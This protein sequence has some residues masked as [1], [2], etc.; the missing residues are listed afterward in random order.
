[1]ARGSNS[2]RIHADGEGKL[3]ATVSAGL[4]RGLEAVDRR[5]GQGSAQALLAHQAAQGPTRQGGR[6]RGL[7]RRLEAIGILQAH[8]DGRPVHPRRLEGELPGRFESSLLEERLAAALDRHLGDLSRFV[9]QE[10]KDDLGGGALFAQ[11]FGGSPGSPRGAAEVRSRARQ[12]SRP[13]P[14]RSRH[15]LGRRRHPRARAPANR[16]RRPLAKALRRPLR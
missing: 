4:R 12:P 14:L 6:R 7:G 9:D 15:R 11:R 10:P 13:A 1:M 8:G 2:A 3:E 5:P 16:R